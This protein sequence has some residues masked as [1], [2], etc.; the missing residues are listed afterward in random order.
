MGEDLWYLV[1]AL[2]LFTLMAGS[3]SAIL[4]FSFSAVIPLV[5]Y[6]IGLVTLA[7]GLYNSGSSRESR[8]ESLKASPEYVRLVNESDVLRFDIKNLE[9]KIKGRADFEQTARAVALQWASDEH[10]P[11][12]QELKNQLARL[13]D[14]AEQNYQDWL[15]ESLPGGGAVPIIDNRM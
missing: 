1:S 15:K 8:I 13:L 11:T 12:R 6:L 9:N 2:G 3:I 10:F 5:L 7:V 14:E 4:I